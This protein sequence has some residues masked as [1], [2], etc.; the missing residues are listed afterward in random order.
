MPALAVVLADYTLPKRSL[1]R[2]QTECIGPQTTLVPPTRRIGPE[3]R[4]QAC[5]KRRYLPPGAVNSLRRSWY[6]RGGFL[7]QFLKP[8][9]N[10]GPV[11][12]SL[13]LL[14]YDKQKS[15]FLIFRNRLFC[16]SYFWSRRPLRTAR[17]VLETVKKTYPEPRK[18]GGRPTATVLVSIR[19]IPPFFQRVRTEV[20]QNHC[21]GL[22]GCSDGRL[23]RSE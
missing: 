12:S 21:H 6:F 7:N 8:H 9:N 13:L 16:L 11:R 5:E 1:E 4:I 19:G 15:R 18:K 23:T 17:V 2:P 10:T 3:Q 14:K 20:E 22:P